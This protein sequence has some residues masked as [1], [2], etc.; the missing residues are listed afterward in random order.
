MYLNQ[1]FAPLFGPSG[2]LGQIADLSVS[3]VPGY[4]PGTPPNPAFQPWVACAQHV[5]NCTKTDCTW[6]SVL[7]CAESGQTTIAQCESQARMPSASSALVSKCT[8]DSSLSAKLVDA[9]HSTAEKGGNVVPNCY[10]NGQHS[11]GCFNDNPVD[12][13]CQAYTGSD[14]PPACNSKHAEG[15]ASVPPSKW[16]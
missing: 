10:I 4:H 15:R 7:E 6:Y 9:M 13:I 16:D 5:L 12:T 14:K 1:H 8:A 3:F 11:V 2:E